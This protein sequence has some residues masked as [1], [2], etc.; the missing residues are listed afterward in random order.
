MNYLFSGK[1]QLPYQGK[2]ISPRDCIRADTS[3]IVVQCMI[4]LLCGGI[5][6]LRV[7]E[8]NTGQYLPHHKI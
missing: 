1:E 6:L 2:S 8:K 3:R 7:Q 5:P 4:F